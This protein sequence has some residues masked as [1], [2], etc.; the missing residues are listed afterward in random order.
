MRPFVKNDITGFAAIVALLTMLMAVP[1]AL[2]QDESDARAMGMG[3][4]QTALAR[5]TEAY[6]WNPANLGLQDQGTGKIAIAGA[7][8]FQAGTNTFS[9]VDYFVYNGSKIKTEDWEDILDKIHNE[10]FVN[11]NIDF[12]WQ[13]FSVRYLN[14]AFSLS[15]QSN[16]AARVPREFFDIGFKATTDVFEI[17]E[18][19]INLTARG[20]N[21]EFLVWNFSG[22]FS[23]N[24]FFGE[25]VKDASAGLTLKYLNGLQSHDLRKAR[26]VIEE[27]D[28]IRSSGLY[29]YFESD[30]GNGFAMDL[31]L[32]TK[33]S[34][35]WTV[36]MSFQNLF[37]SISWSSKSKRHDGFYIVDGDDGNSLIENF[38]EDNKDSTTHVDSY[39]TNLP[40]ILRIGT[41]Y[42]VR[43]GLNVT[44]DYEVFM[45]DP[46]QMEPEPRLGTGIEYWAQDFV[47]VRGGMTVGGGN[48]GFNLTAGVGFKIRDRV[49]IDFALGNLEGIFNLQRFS[50]ALGAKVEI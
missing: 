34:S 8:G 14:Y 17:G 23:L 3:G 35:K 25:Y 47:A 13:F 44:A 28:G 32:V 40:V 2:A 20:R 21:D 26:A 7:S 27:S 22:G 49:K 39:S 48:R 4:A 31:G 41:N 16:G 1:V 38:F 9:V 24:R 29:R 45:T 18:E 6:L 15:K 10:D 37:N 50:A 43:Y 46:Y 11:A 5:S 30:G 19:Q 36:G 33:I 42:R 12:Q